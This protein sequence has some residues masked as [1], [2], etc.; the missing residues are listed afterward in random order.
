MGVEDMDK[1][2][3]N[4]FSENEINNSYDFSFEE[5]EECQSIFNGIYFG[6]S[7]FMYDAHRH[8]RSRLL[9]DRS[10]GVTCMIHP[11]WCGNWAKNHS[12]LQGNQCFS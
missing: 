7:D 2:F 1:R 6:L 9:T 11:R 3:N 10:G 5:N 4:H 12:T 8:S